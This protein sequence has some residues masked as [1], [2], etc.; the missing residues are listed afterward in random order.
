[1][2]PIVTSCCVFFL[3]TASMAA[4][5]WTDRK[6]YDLVLTIRSESS[7]EKRLALLDSWSKSYPQ[8]GLARARQEL[9]LATY[10]SMGDRAHM[11]GTAKQMLAAQPNNPVGLYWLTVLAP[12]QPDVSSEIID[13]G[14][15]AAHQL[16]AAMNEYFS[17]DKKPPNMTAADWQKQ[18]LLVEVLAQRTEGWANLQRGNFGAANND[19]SAC[20][21][22]DPGNAEI[23]SLLG[24][25]SA[26]DN[27][28]KQPQ[29]LWQLARATSK[30]L[31][32]P[33]AEDQRRQVNTMLENMYVS[34]HGSLEGLDQVRKLSAS[35]P[36][37]PAEFTV[38]AAT[39][40]NAR[41]AEAEL[42]L[43]NPTLAAWLVMRRQLEAADGEKYFAADLQGKQ[44]PQLSGTVLHAVPAKAPREITLSMNESSTADVTLKLTVPLTSAVHP[45]VKI[46]FQGNGDSFIKNPFSLVVTGDAA[47]VVK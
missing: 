45:G 20:L 29:A 34:Y 35:N 11:F 18:K 22:K 4:A 8:T 43:T 44:L 38:D 6:E 31:P 33:L 3:A 36:I 30:D 2:K 7:P 27:T 16:L 37:P 39:V 12:Q 17:A 40:V 26:L 1:M 13:A 21:K 23:S 28:N 46:T 10:E 32:T 42:S 9:Y 41:R 5:D 24:I 25:V 47:Q 15:K 19:F 14:D